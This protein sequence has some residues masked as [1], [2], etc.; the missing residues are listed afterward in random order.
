MKCRLCGAELYSEYAE[1]CPS[2]GMPVEGIPVVDREAQ[3]ADLKSYQQV[4]FGVAAI[5]LLLTLA[6]AFLPFFKISSGFD[7]RLSINYTLADEGLI[8]DIIVI[9]TICAVGG[10]V[11]F[12]EKRSS[13][14]RQ[15]VVGG[16]I[17][18]FALL[19]FL[20][21]QSRF[22]VLAMVLVSMYDGMHA[23]LGFYLMLAGGIFLIM[24]GCV[25]L[26]ARKKNGTLGKK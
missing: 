20:G 17:I 3:E 26:C 15:I 23:D 18:A 1:I 7:T 8:G 25:M 22:A 13:G 10:L 16:M 4:S 2:C 19:E 5:G 9:C 21:L 14:I 12:F 24:A 11:I 6:G